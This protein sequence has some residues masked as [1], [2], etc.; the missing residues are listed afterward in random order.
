MVSV[1]NELKA[2]AAAMSPAAEPKPVKSAAVVEEP[3]PALSL[4]PVITPAVG[5]VASMV[6]TRYQV[7]IL[8]AQEKAALAAALCRLAD[9]YKLRI[10]DEKVA[11]WLGL[12]ATAGAIIM[13]R[14]KV[15]A[16]AAPADPAP[17]VQAEAVAA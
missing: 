2:E 7:A 1:L 9:A 10:Q 14:V 4:V 15:P 6:T 8:E 13:P 16:P 17:A 12:A 3:D 5:L 11:A